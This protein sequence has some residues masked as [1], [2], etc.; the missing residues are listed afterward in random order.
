MRSE[1]S[2]RMRHWQRERLCTKPALSERLGRLD[3]PRRYQDDPGAGAPGQFSVILTPAK[4]YSFW[5]WH[6]IGMKPSR[7]RSL[8][9]PSS[10]WV[11]A[12]QLRLDE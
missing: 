10:P 5:Q 11:L 7:L 8:W 2:H 3:F 1:R 9:A 6:G 4:S 12:H